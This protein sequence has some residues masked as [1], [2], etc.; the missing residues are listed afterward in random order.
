[1]ARFARQ[2]GGGLILLGDSFT[3]L[4][5]TLIADLA[6][7]YRL[8]S[9]AASTDFAKGGGLM[10]YGP[11]LG[12]ADQYRQAATYIDRILKGVKPSDLPVQTPT[13]YRL[14]INVKTAKA[15]G[16]AI[17]PSLLADEVIE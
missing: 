8:P 1:L 2:P 12:V 10:D 16:I 5:Q 13:K 14:V 4:H 6:S 17:P 7:R 9:I 15:L 3:R 11:Y